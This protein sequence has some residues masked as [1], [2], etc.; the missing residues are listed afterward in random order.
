[1]I[2]GNGLLAVKIN[3]MG[4]QQGYVS[5]EGPNPLDYMGIY[6]A[7][8]SIRLAEWKNGKWVKYEDHTQAVDLP[9]TWIK[10]RDTTVYK[11]SRY[12]ELYCYKTQGGG[13]NFASWVRQAAANVGR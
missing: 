7:G 11:L 9:A 10:P 6:N 12:A 1:M 8:G 4:N 5:Q 13:A 3:L 2:K